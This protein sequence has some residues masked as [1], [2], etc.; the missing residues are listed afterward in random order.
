MQGLTILG[1][2]IMGHTRTE[3]HP[4]SGA[5][6]KAISTIKKAQQDQL[7]ARYTNMAKRGRSTMIAELGTVV[8]QG[9]SRAKVN[10]LLG[11]MS[12]NRM[13]KAA[14]ETDSI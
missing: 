9:C 6:E 14:P 3:L 10:A 13:L 5:E 12:D 8:V 4:K 2:L 7:L 1:E 11:V